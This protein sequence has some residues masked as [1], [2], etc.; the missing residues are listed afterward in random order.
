MLYPWYTLGGD[1]RKV[2]TPDVAP[3]TARL[4]TDNDSTTA[5]LRLARIAAMLCL[6]FTFA[7]GSAWGTDVTYT[8]TST[9]AVSTSGTAPGGSSASYSQ[10]YSTASQMTTGNSVTLT[11]T[12]LGGINISNITLS[13]KS[14]KSS[15]AGKLKYS[16]DG[17]S[18]WT[19]LVGSSGSTV[20]FNNSSWYGSWSQLYVNV[21]K[22]VSLSAVTQLIITIEAT[23]N[24]LYCE[25]FKLTYTTSG[26]TITTSVT[27]LS[28][29]GYSTADFTQQ[30]KSFTVS[31]SSLT[32]NVTVTA[33]T[34]FEVCKTSGGTYTS[35]VTFDKGSGTLA[36]S[37][38]YV[39]LQS[40]ESAGSYDGDVTC[41]ST[42][43]TSKTVALSGS[44][45]FTVT[46]QANGSLHAT[47]YVAY[48]TSPG[49]ALGTL[50]DDPDP[51]DY[52]CSTKSFY[53][54][55][56][57]NSYTNASVA[58]STISTSTKITSDKTYNA[59]FATASGTTTTW[60]L[61]AL[62]AVTAGTYAIVNQSNK[63]F[64]GTITS[65]HG[66]V[67]SGTFSFTD[68]VATSAPTGTCEITF[69]VQSDGFSMY[70]T[71]SSKYLYASQ[72]ASG[73]LAEQTSKPSDYWNYYSP[74]WQYHHNYSSKY[75][76]LRSASST[77][78]G[79]RIYGAND[80]DGVVQLAKKTSVTTYS[81]YATSCGACTAS[82]V[83]GTASLNGPFNLSTV[84][85]QCASI[86]P[87]TNCS[88]ASG[89]YGFIWYAGTGNKK[90]NEAGVTKVAVTSGAYSSGSF[91]KNL[92][93]TFSLGSTYTFRAFAINGK[94]D[95]VYSA[96][97]SFTPRSVTFN[98]NSHGS[99]AP[100]TQYV[101]NGGKAT[102]PSYSESVSG[103]RF[104]GWYGNASCTGNA[105]SF[106]DSIVSGANRTLYAKWTRV[107]S[108]TYAYAGG[109]S[110]C[111]D[112]TKYAAGATVTVCST[113]P[114]K[115]GSTFLGWLGDN[116]VGTKAAGATFS[117]PAANVTLTAQWEDTEYTLTQTKS[118]HT[119]SSVSATK[120]K[121]GDLVST[122]KDFV[123]T[124]SNIAAN[125]G[126]ALPKTPTL[127]GGGQTWERGT[128]YTWTLS[129]DRHS[130]TLHIAADL[131]ISANLT[132]NVSEVTRYL[133]E[134]DEHGSIDSVYYASDDNSVTMK[135]GIDDCGTKKFYCWTENSSFVSHET[136]PPAAASSGSISGDKHYYAIYADA[137]VPL[138]PGYN[139]VTSGV[140]AGTYLIVTDAG[141]AYA[142]RNSS[143]DYGAYTS[144]T[145][146]AGVIASKGSAQEVT[147]TMSSSNFHMNDGTYYLGYSGSS[148]DMKF[149]T[150][151][152][153]NRDLWKLDANGQI[154]SVNVSGR[155]L[156]YNSGSPR[157]ACYTG[158]QTY[159]FLYKKQTTTYSNYA[160]TCTLYDISIT[161]PSHG[162]VSTSPTAG[163]DA[164]G[165]GQTITVTAT[166]DACY[167]LS[168]LKYN[169]GS[170]HDILSTKSFTMPSS[171]VTITATFSAK[172]VSSIAATTST[173]RTLMQGT[174]FVGEQITV[175][176]SDGS[177]EVLDW[178]DSTLDFNNP[179]MSTLG[180]QTVTVD[181]DG[182]CGTASVD[183]DIEIVD[184]VPVTY[185]DGNTTYV[186]KYEL[187]ATVGIDT[188]TGKNGCDGYTF[189]GWSDTQIST[190]DDEYVPVHNFAASTAR[191]LY[192]VYAI[193]KQ[194][195]WMSI[196][197]EASAK[198]GAKYSIVAVYSSDKIYELTP[199]TKNTNYLDGTE[200]TANIN[201]WRAAGTYYDYYVR[202]AAPPAANQWEFIKYGT[203][204]YIYNPNQSKYLQTTS[205]GYLKISTAVL[206][207]FTVN[208]G[209]TDCAKTVTSAI[210]SK[211]VRWY[212]SDKEW[213]SYAS[214][215][216][217][218][219]TKDSLFTTN[220]PCSPRSAKFH[221]NGGTVTAYGGGESGGN[222]VVTEAE[223]D[224]GIKLPTASFTACDGKTWTF[225]GWMDEE[226]DL[227]RV[228]I[229]TT[230]LLNDG[231]A[232]GDVDHSITADDE[233]YWAVYSSTGEAETK[234]GTISF[235][236]A[237]FNKSYSSS[238]TTKDK[239]VSDVGDYTFGYKHI[240]HSS[241]I[242]I[243]IR[244]ADD[245]PGEFYN[246]TSLGKI[247]KISFSSFSSGD[248]S[249]LEV[250]VGDEEKTTDHKLTSSELQVIGTT[251]TYYPSVDGS[252]FYI[253]NVDSYVCLSGISV[254]FGRGTVIYATTPDCASISLSGDIYVTSRN[255]I[256][257][258]AVTPLTVEAHQLD[259]DADVVITSNSSDVY[260][261]AA[262]NANFAMAAANQ[263][264]NSVTVTADGEGE[265]ET[266]VYVH[267]KPSSTG[268]GAASDVTVSANLS[269]ADPDV[270]A[271]H[272]IHVRNL[273]EKIV[274]AAKVGGA[275]YALPANMSTATNPA[276]VLI[277]VDE[278]SMTATA[279]VECTYKIW[280]V[281]TVNPASSD[282]DRY[283][284]NSVKYDGN[285]F[286][287]R[288]RFSAPNN[289]STAN[290]GLW[291][292][293][294]VSGT[295]INDKAAITAIGDGGTSTNNNP[296]YEWKIT[297]TV[298]DG[299]W[300]NTLQTDQ[301]NDKKYLRY[302]T[303]ASGGPKWGM[304]ASGENNLYLLPVTEV[305]PFEME[306]V[307][308]YPTKV[309]VYTT[310]TLSSPTVKVNSSTVAAATCTSKGDNLYEI[311]NL[312][313]TGNPTKSL[314]ISYTST[315]VN[316]ACTKTIP[317][318]I[319][320]STQNVTA[321]PFTTL[322]T[323]VYNSADL[324]VRDNATLTLN[325]T[326]A[327][328]TF[329]NV[330]I[331]PTGKISVPSD[332]KITADNVTFFGGIDDIYNGST[333]ST[334]KYGVP[335]L[336]LKGTVG[337]AL[338]SMDYVMRVDLSQMYALALP[339]DVDLD[340]ITYWDGT[341]MTPGTDLYISAYDGQARAN[342]EKAWV[343]EE[344]FEDKFGSA[345]LGAG[346]GYTISAELQ[347]GF[348]NTYSII[349]LPMQSSLAANATETAKSV[350][351]T[352]Y[353]NNQGATVTDNH[354]GWNFVGNPYMATISGSSAGGASDT[355]LI[356]G[357]LVPNT[358]VDPWD[359]SYMWD[360]TTYP[361]RYVTIPSDD[362]KENEQKKWAD[363]TL[364]PFKNFFIQVGTSGDLA[365]ALASRADA[366]A[367]YALAPGREVEFEIILNNGTRQDH[368]GLLLADIY[369]P[370]YEIN[371]DL[372]KMENT[373]SVY[374][375]T[376]GYKLAYNAL[377]P[378]DAKQPIPVGYI[379]N[380][381]G[382]YT[383]RLD[384][385]S[386][387]TEVE[388]IWLTDYELDRVVDLMDAAY[389][390][391]TVAGRNE[392][393]FALTIEL[394]SNEGVVTSIE[395]VLTGSDK[396]AAVKFIHNDK[397]YILR[398]GLLYD[399]T[400][401]RVNVTNK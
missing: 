189:V 290:A 83:I 183:Y 104:D 378:D 341:A 71:S 18:N 28:D 223:R 258:M 154:E 190:T 99:S 53:G 128:N 393:R 232:S 142:G 397:L 300:N 61:T 72:A 78:G 200:I 262:K 102:D 66:N 24:S 283:T 152:L 284:A 47:T 25:S 364:K 159:A 220:P 33:P 46:W 186:R 150:S 360:G 218:L 157:F 252:Y 318:I 97:V 134:W 179:D 140:T 309:L 176:Y 326:I 320:R 244:A 357:K 377:S 22:S 335:E 374:T 50:P 171:D 44:V 181:Y 192:A 361:Y 297:T 4:W 6:L 328:N 94:P 266:T 277:D 362:G 139:K 222:L 137:A 368:T 110:S 204:F 132:I 310:N 11:L 211:N 19:Y 344:D 193:Q 198:S 245:G 275:Y 395:D 57:G 118:A 7:V 45:P 261:S 256:G 214:G 373:L 126:Y 343:Y 199:T 253:K 305:T 156:E 130:A 163:T 165:A 178:D 381:A 60:V 265:L 196:H 350:A 274:I 161:T 169:D 338:S 254:D 242:G 2:F 202:S 263:P 43:A 212:N 273:S 90:L 91:S 251:Y 295:T 323:G 124:I 194:T 51:S 144:V 103:W 340:D 346:V 366:P 37:T 333:Y 353:V 358:D 304:Y 386:E 216:V 285:A 21:S 398:N 233:E 70:N 293:N 370:A 332:K 52:T 230:E 239:T 107:Y 291:A 278:S 354:K 308:W 42:G 246:K 384:E 207:S 112:D 138:S 123:Y 127:S 271:N 32:A 331:C 173:H 153:D 111:S 5:R 337:K 131:T 348:G 98:L 215:T 8:V 175:T 182:D 79:L 95:T 73:G 205:D 400:G 209:G 119:T 40:G 68:G 76:R 155:L 356:V 327:Q 224:A 336:S 359:G 237:D 219:L 347:S 289:T 174:S 117:M 184:G 41:T 96:A 23:A 197:D 77:P 330:T 116:S 396:D 324:V 268:T 148:N 54:W 387:V 172:S 235:A 87:G 141:T 151:V 299:K 133:V 379:A 88:V 17:G 380:E 58:P 59:V 65:G 185:H 351:V 147:I 371:A 187:A 12:S 89:D 249:D 294:E 231:A 382:L 390:F 39:R 86:T 145:I 352:A 203:K 247:N 259:A 31:G 345:T 26:P 322:T 67:T 260:F 85:V 334:N 288:V 69:E 307:E 158:G 355:K 365:F 167:Y 63:A 213:T 120:I 135:T 75:A 257:I 20:N 369:S 82:A 296:S 180:D 394:Q 93:S 298:T 160:K 226:R 225:M 401:K 248:L 236:M 229:L 15:G 84:G 106:A 74:N 313:L 14:N 115:A 391:T 281:K 16:T 206:D 92:T 49:T 129:D 136:T 125:A 38:V 301:T 168:A 321:E 363:V 35:S 109:T 241:D 238:E 255:G 48:A 3:T 269:P 282:Y 80:G 149:N 146:S 221:G 177:T 240:G 316:Y 302:W 188:I 10:T 13:M 292:N 81:N 339:Y 286:G 101:N 108:V 375:L 34:G 208:D 55:Y 62:N 276:G 166:P 143:N 303:A 287:D 376:G 210:T 319:S 325:G 306:V 243:Q 267:Y 162:E 217:L 234:Y 122:G 372:E 64:D 388:H 329:A 389:D 349:R 201:T 170:D 342:R 264:K 279:P 312:D 27:S 114:T 121:S 314:T 399:A 113:P 29:V 383:F 191:T 367:R 56:D 311:A 9:S 1:T 270:T 227:S 100:S 228:P 317:V 36:A 250:Y 392:T 195:N 164:A 385:N 280:P 272:T 315:A 30:V 105:W